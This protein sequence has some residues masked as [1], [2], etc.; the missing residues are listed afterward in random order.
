MATF[1]VVAH[2]TREHAV[3]HEAIQADNARRA[4]DDI[5]L[6]TTHDAD[7]R[8]RS[9]FNCQRVHVQEV[10]EGRDGFRIFEAH[11]L[12]PE[13]PSWTRETEGLWQWFNASEVW[14]SLARFF[15]TQHSD[16]EP[17]CEA[18]GKEHA[19]RFAMADAMQEFFEVWRDAIITGG[20]TEPVWS[21]Y[22]K[23]N[24][25]SEHIGAEEARRVIVSDVGS[26]WRVEWDKLAEHLM[27]IYREDWEEAGEEDPDDDDDP[28]PVEEIDPL[29]DDLPDLEKPLGR[30]WL[31]GEKAR[32]DS[33]S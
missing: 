33:E 11:E 1:D 14:L 18:I 30:I 20:L 27:D 9:G 24:A 25:Y 3:R 12:D 26:L 5:Y 29:P 13:V 8:R 19:I 22:D 32:Q 23:R 6:Q 2:F 10:G 21:F 16:A 17:S 28:E 15:V 4:A 7:G 31:E